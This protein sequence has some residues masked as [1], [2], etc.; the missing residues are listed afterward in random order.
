MYEEEINYPTLPDDQGDS[1]T[2]IWDGYLQECSSNSQCDGDNVCID[3]DKTTDYAEDCCGLC[4]DDDH[5]NGDLICDNGLCI[6]DD[7][8]TTEDCD[9]GE[10]CSEGQCIDEYCWGD[11]ECED[12][13]WH[14]CNSGVCEDESDNYEDC[15][16][17]DDC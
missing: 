11:H 6:Y 4:Y 10:Y 15:T 12:G 13:W 1:E 3:S 8:D 17:D 2:D 9:C 7:C 16:D 14:V 5:C